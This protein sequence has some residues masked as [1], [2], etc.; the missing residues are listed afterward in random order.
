MSPII[1]EATPSAPETAVRDAISRA[2]QAFRVARAQADDSALAG[3]GTGSWLEYERAQVA[4]LRSQGARQQWIATR[5]EVTGH[6]ISGDRAAACTEEN[7]S[8]VEISADGT[9]SPP[10][11]LQYVEH[12]TLSLQNGAWLVEAIDYPSDSAVCAAKL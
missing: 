9:Q 12:Y 3:V 4:Q 10:E 5:V 7:W 11:T 6:Q 2:N 1:G 8:R